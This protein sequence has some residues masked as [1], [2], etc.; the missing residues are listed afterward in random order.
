[1]H[2]QAERGRE[3]REDLNEEVQREKRETG[4]AGFR[5]QV[6]NICD[7]KQAHLREQGK[8]VMIKGDVGES[9]RVW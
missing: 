5:L 8:G 1:M 4:K 2:T 3:G 9:E 6:V 7:D